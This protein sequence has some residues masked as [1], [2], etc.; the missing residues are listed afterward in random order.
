MQYEEG[1]AAVFWSEVF[2]YII[3][4]WCSVRKWQDF[5]VT[6]LVHL[7]QL[8]CVA[9]CNGIRLLCGSWVIKKYC[10]SSWFSKLKM[11]LEFHQGGSWFQMF[12]WSYGEWSLSLFKRSLVFCVVTYDQIDWFF[13]NVFTFSF[14]AS[15]SRP[16]CCSVL[17]IANCKRETVKIITIKDWLSM[18]QLWCKQCWFFET[19]FSICDD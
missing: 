1:Y 16:H 12:M 18:N 6:Y 17:R 7:G 15:S 4:F 19:D 3:K 14:K 8:R 10:D 9:A 2:L 5:H 11:F 13:T